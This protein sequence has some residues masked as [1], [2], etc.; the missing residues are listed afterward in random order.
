[1]RI[2]VSTIKVELKIRVKQITVQSYIYWSTLGSKLSKLIIKSFLLRKI[3]NRKPVNQSQRNI[4]FL[5]YYRTNILLTSES[6]FN[7]SLS[8]S[9]LKR[10]NIHRSPLD[11]LPL[12]GE[13]TW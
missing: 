4:K 5:Y 6:N 7:F 1:M 8:S 10:T 13:K 2:I 11:K 3:L 12:S 9:P